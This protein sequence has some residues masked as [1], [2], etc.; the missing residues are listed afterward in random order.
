MEKINNNNL[1]NK[2]F[3]H[4][5][6]ENFLK[7][8]EIKKLKDNF[9]D[10][11]L[12]NKFNRRNDKTEE[13][14][15]LYV[16]KK[17]DFNKLE[18]KDFWLNLY[19]KFNNKKFLK[20]VFQLLGKNLPEKESHLQMQLIYDIQNY[21][22]L[23]HCDTKLNSDTKFLTMLFYLNEDETL[24]LGTELYIP[25]KK[26]DIKIIEKNEEKK[27]SIYK[28]APYKINNLLLF[29]PEY[30]KSW[31]GVSKIKK[32]V[33]RKTI[34]IFLKNKKTINYDTI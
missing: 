23:P 24:D 28:K 6:I 21:E 25:D 15:I 13:R 17:E 1:H 14:H 29:I 4:L 12:F 11:K 7:Q 30:D 32:N 22:I 33:I 20:N 16:D 8:D 34:Q 9:P 26:G 27:F 19:N 18:N 2:P 10:N 31:H 5:I 3:K